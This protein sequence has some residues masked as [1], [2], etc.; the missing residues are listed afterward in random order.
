MDKRLSSDDESNEVADSHVVDD[1][2]HCNA[3]EE[4]EPEFLPPTSCLFCN[5][6]SERIKSNLDH[7]SSEH[8]LFIPDPEHVTDMATLVRYLRIIIN[9]FHECLYCGTSR[10]SR[11]GIQQHM[12][13]RGHCMVNFELEPDLL[14]FWDFS[15]SDDDQ[16]EI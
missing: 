4:I 12:H 10:G 14:D 15:D 5:R 16:N 9:E 1:Q 3:S 11:D 8:G 7:M 6:V 13:D 2:N